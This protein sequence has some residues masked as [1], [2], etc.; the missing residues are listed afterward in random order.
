MHFEFHLSSLS[1]QPPRLKGYLNRALWIRVSTNPL[2]V[3]EHQHF[4]WVSRVR[5]QAPLDIEHRSI[6]N[7]NP[8]A[9]FR[10]CERNFH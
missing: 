10:I 6:V 3:A 9:I 7:D 1:S 8:L 2:R 5:T 4:H